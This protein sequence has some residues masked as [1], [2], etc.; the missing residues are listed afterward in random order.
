VTITGTLVG[1]P[2]LLKQSLWVG[3]RKTVI[4][5]HLSNRH[6]EGAEGIQSAAALFLKYL[7]VCRHQR[8]A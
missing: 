1:S 3:S 8:V 5:V 4:I 6:Q 7:R 2:K